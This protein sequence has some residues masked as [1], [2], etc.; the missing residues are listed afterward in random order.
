MPSFVNING[1]KEDLSCINHIYVVP[2]KEF[3]CKYENI[4]VREKMK[5]VKVIL[6]KFFT[7][8]RQLPS[9]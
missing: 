8:E 3:L 7:K 1:K 5:L 4:A 2:I 6:E 9:M